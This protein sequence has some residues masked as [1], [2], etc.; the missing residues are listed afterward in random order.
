[1][2]KSSFGRGTF[3]L[4]LLFLLIGVI[5]VAVS[6]ARGKASLGIF[7]IF[8]FVVGAD[9]YALAGFCFIFL[10]F[11]LWFFL[12]FWHLEREIGYGEGW[13]KGRE[14]VSYAVNT[15]TEKKAGGVLFIGPIPIIF[16]SDPKTALLIA[17][18]G[19]MILVVLVL[20]MLSLR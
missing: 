16:G 18:V 8:P 13:G 3:V 19:F 11:I 20:L 4:S 17:V 6:V 7:L 1:M 5:L 10:S 2:F 9:L 15:E 12:P 14:G